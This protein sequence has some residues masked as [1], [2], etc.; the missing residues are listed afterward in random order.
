MLVKDKHTSSALPVLPLMRI[1][2]SITG[3]YG[4]HRMVCFEVTDQSPA[5]FRAHNRVG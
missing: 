3:L 2:P 4:L 5:P 1:V